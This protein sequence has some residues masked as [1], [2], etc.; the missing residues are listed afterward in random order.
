MLPLI[1]AISAGLFSYVIGRKGAAFLTT[2]LMFSNVF[3]T[4]YIFYKTSFCERLYF[5][6]L[7]TWIYSDIFQIDWGFYIDNLTITMLIVVNVVSALVHLYSTD[8]MAHDPH[9]SRF[10]SYLSLFTF[11]M[12]ILVTG[13][14]FAILFL[15]WEGVGL[16]SYLLI[17]FWYT[18]LQANKAAIKALIVN[19]VADFALTIGMVTIFF[20]F[21]SLDFHVVFPLA[22]FFL[23]STITFLNFEIPVLPMICTL[24]FVGAM[25]KSAQIGLHTWLPDAM[26]GPT[27]V[28]A[29]IHAAT[30]VTAGVFLIIKCSPLFEYVPSVLSF[31]TFIGATTAFFSATIGLVQNDIK[32]V[33][34]YST[35][36]QLGYMVFAC[37]LSNYHVSLFHLANHAFFKALLFLSAGAIIHSLSNEQ[38]MRKYGSLSPLLPFT[39]IMLLIGSLSLMGFPFLTGYYSKDLIL[40]LAFTKYTVEGSF[41]YALGLITAFFTSYYSFRVFYMTF[42]YKNNSFRQVIL[43]VHELPYKMAIA[44]SILSLGSIFLGYF[45]KDLLVGLGTDFWNQSIF[46]LPRNNNQLDA[47]FFGLANLIENES[48]WNSTYPYRFIK[49]LPFFSSLVAVALVCFL[50]SQPKI[51]FQ[52]KNKNDATQFNAPYVSNPSVIF[53]QQTPRLFVQNLAG[54]LKTDLVRNQTELNRLIAFYSNINSSTNEEITRYFA[55]DIDQATSLSKEL[56]ERKDLD[57]YNKLTFDFQDPE[58]LTRNSDYKSWLRSLYKF[59]SYKW[60]F[61]AIYN[62]LINRPLLRFAYRTTFKSFDKGFLEIFGPHGIS[63][64]LFK[65]AFEIKKMHVGQAYYYAY[66]MVFFLI[67][68]VITVYHIIY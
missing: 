38:D 34:A 28:S 47:E 37:G 44:L 6:K 7:G 61:D 53:D 5:V 16:C 58:L 17:S 40:E 20:V 66:F 33:I 8:Y 2:A 64:V 15:G 21:K 42:I 67:I 10:M 39:S 4:F 45:S 14:N 25:G 68:N 30:M 59:L 51:N 52:K 48:L 35:C 9:L 65:S 23:N 11:F 46:I 19:R 24:L 18:R 56:L 57:Y 55:M 43:H 32:K 41:A 49:L 12:L 26:E 62:E 3:L 63:T 27:P 60:Y 36:S 22:P 50:F 13:D 31:I 1:G 29:L 54:S